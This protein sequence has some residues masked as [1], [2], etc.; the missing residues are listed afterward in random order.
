MSWDNYGCKRGQWTI[1]HTVPF[2]AFMTWDGELEE[3]KKVL[4]WW[5]NTRPMWQSDN[6][7]KFDAYTEEDKQALITKYIINQRLKELI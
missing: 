1:D 3:Y 2:K 5:R 7:S 6:L 4:C